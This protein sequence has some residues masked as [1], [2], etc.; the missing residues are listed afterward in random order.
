MTSPDEQSRM[1]A[2]CE[3]RESRLTDWEREFV[4]SLRERID[5]GRGLTPKQSEVL[6][7][8]WDRATARG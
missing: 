3:Q 1:V 7:E 2:D 5:S 6:D 4:Q 8:I